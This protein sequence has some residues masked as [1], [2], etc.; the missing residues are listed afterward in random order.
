MDSFVNDILISLK[1]PLS[2]HFSAHL[3]SSVVIVA[4][5]KIDARIVNDEESM[6]LSIAWKVI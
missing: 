1:Y 2:P 4:Q 5:C 6:V 3:I